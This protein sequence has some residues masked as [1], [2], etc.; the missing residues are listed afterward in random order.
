MNTSQK[1]DFRL[2]EG[3]LLKLLGFA[4][5][6]L[7]MIEADMENLSPEE[8][9]AAKEL[10]HIINKIVNIHKEKTNG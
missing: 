4:D 1:I 8:Q 10:R 9:R 6:M 3:Q 5:E 7:A 2:P